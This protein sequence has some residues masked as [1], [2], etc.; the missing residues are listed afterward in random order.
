MPLIRGQRRRRRVQPVVFRP[1]APLRPRPPP[2]CR[3]A[4]CP[5]S[6]IEDKLGYVFWFKEMWQLPSPNFYA[7]DRYKDWLMDT[8]RP[9]G[10]KVVCVPA[11][12]PASQQWMQMQQWPY[13]QL[14]LD[15]LY[16]P[17]QEEDGVVL[18]IHKGQL[19]AALG[20]YGEGRRWREEFGCDETL[21]RKVYYAKW[22]LVTALIM[23]GVGA[24]VGVGLGAC[25]CCVCSRRKSRGKGWHGTGE[26][27]GRE[28]REKTPLMDIDMDGERF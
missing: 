3:P 7:L 13:R 25:C 14:S 24:A 16:Q 6:P 17:R 28:E 21:S 4:G 9:L 5:C 20:E 18:S 27:R 23:L 19:L 8:A 11:T 1:H 26:E 12:H 22:Q 15:F 10:M 2:P